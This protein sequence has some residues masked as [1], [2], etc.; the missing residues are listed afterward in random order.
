MRVA[1][2]AVLRWT[3]LSVALGTLTIAG[4]VAAQLAPD[5][6]TPAEVA[7]A[8]GD[9]TEAAPTGDEEPPSE[10][11][12]APALEPG[13]DEQTGIEGRV[14]A[15]DTEQGLPDAPVLI[16]GRGRVRSV[17][18]DERGAYRL[19]LP[20]GR[21]IVR[22]Y[23]DMY[24][25]ASL[26]GVQVPRGRV[27]EANL[28]LDPIEA[29]DIVVEDMEVVY[30]ADTSSALAQQNLRRETVGAVDAISAAEISRNG[31][32][33]AAAAARRVVGVTVDSGNM[34]VVRGLGGRYSAVL[35]NGVLLPSTDPDNPG[36]QLDIFPVNLLSSMSISKTFRPDLP[37]SWAGGIMEL[38]TRAFPDRLTLQLRAS[39]GVNT[40]STFRDRLDY[41]GGRLDFLGFDDGTRRM[42]A[43]VPGEQLVNTNGTFTRAQ[44]TEFGK[45]F[46]NVWQYQRRAALPNGSLG[47]TFGNT[48]RLGHDVRLG[49]LFSFD[50]N[51]YQRRTTGLLRPDVQI[52]APG[53]APPCDDPR[54]RLCE[55]SRYAIETGQLQVFWGTLANVSLA[56]G[57][58]HEI[59]ALSFFNRN[60]TDSTTLRSVFLNSV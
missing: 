51:S 31:D 28:T 57:D 5:A 6:G 1:P 58:D 18:T 11:I 38:G 59:T 45:L 3:A 36:V 24:H 55:E 42:P 34:L 47:L 44:I 20:P 50:Y 60:T 26:P 53:A 39:L 15:G 23:F 19:A 16:E 32:S 49:Y 43:G 35:M 2:D 52:A 48:H 4:P 33:N 22:S 30:R 37:G 54:G 29:E 7:P 21:Y 17:L 46:P 27:V 8:D 56:V 12:E 10:A 9:S 25:G 13:A 40:L 41:D 14:V